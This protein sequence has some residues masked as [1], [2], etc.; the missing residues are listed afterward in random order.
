MLDVDSFDHD[1]LGRYGDPVCPDADLL[2]MQ[3]VLKL[4]SPNKGT[5]VLSV[6]VSTDLVVWN[7]HRVYGK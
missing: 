5:L 3:A 6:P 4:L 7:L 2:S 1:G